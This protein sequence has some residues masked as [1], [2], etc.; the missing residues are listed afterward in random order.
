LNT[1]LG[2]E[3]T[4]TINGRYLKKYYPSIEIDRWLQAP[5][6]Q[7]FD[8]QKQPAFGKEA[9]FRTKNPNRGDGQYW[10]V[11]PF[12]QKYSTIQMFLAGFYLTTQL[13]KI[14]RGGKQKA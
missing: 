2:E 7:A 13:L 3:F 6:L 14:T 11:L 5:G 9:A 12:A 10:N 1:L 8:T 4:A